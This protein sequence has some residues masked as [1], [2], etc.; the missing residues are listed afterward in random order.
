MTSRQV[1]FDVRSE[2]LTTIA[3]IVVLLMLI[4]MFAPVVRAAESQETR[5]ITVAVDGSGEFK[6]IQEALASLSEEAPGRTILSLKPGRYQGPILVAKSKP[7]ISFVGS[8]AE[9]TIITYG[10]NVYETQEPQPQGFRDPAADA[11]KHYRGT[12]VVVLGD[13][14]QAADITFQNTSGDHGQAIA[15][16]ID[17]D[18][19]ALKNCRILGWQD[20]LR[21]E[22]GRQYYRECLI[23][24]RVDFIYGGA[25]AVFDRCEI[26][27]KNGGYV[28][29]A[30]TP[31]DHPFG[32]VFLH[33][34]LTADPTS[35]SN[36]FPETPGPPPR[37]F[38]GRP[39]RP[40]ACV[41]FLG[42]EMGDHIRPEGWDNWRKAENEATARYAEYGSTGPGA[43]PEK[44]AGW[45]RQL[46]KE[47]A[48]KITVEAVLAGTDGWRPGD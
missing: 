2:T 15:L 42:C 26:R 35:W 30:S 7:R 17:G 37:A 23:E 18:R 45:S 41:A 32:Y 36:P 22:K 8:G 3:L 28:T 4:V 44:R 31:E 27:S 29:A 20:T 5:T 6:S 24:G 12:G 48:E 33:C 19:A 1:V 13:D 14:F 11:L 38:L 10:L 40:H 34:R 16:R 46:T 47:Q 25:T 39:W 43:N 9:K 21:A